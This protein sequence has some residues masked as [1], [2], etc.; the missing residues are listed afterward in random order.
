MAMSYLP[1]FLAKLAVGMFSGRL[2]DAYCPA[3]GP[4]DSQ[5]L[6]LIIA[7]MTVTTP[8]GLCLFRR[9]ISVKEAGRGP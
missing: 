9:W 8:L 7:L 3:E 4:R 2:L 6:W 5:T 1:F